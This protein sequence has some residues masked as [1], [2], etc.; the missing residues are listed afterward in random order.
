MEVK[1]LALSRSKESKRAW[2]CGASSDS[3]A[4]APVGVEMG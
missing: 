3:G 2:D 4:G 1:P